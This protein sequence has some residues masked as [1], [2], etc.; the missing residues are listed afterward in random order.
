MILVPKH[1][2]QSVSETRINDDFPVLRLLVNQS[3]GISNDA[4]DVQRLPAWRRL[5]GEV[6]EGS[7]D[8][9]Y[10]F[11]LADD[12]IQVFRILFVPSLFLLE[13][14]RASAD[15]PGRDRLVWC[16]DHVKQ[17]FTADKGCDI[18]RC[19][20]SRHDPARKVE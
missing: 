8:V 19:D 9:T 2:R 4:V 6:E 16:Q 17:G 20:D 15:R 7:H 5:A 11:R 1:G 13:Q 14:V 10:A 3:C 18:I 12:Q